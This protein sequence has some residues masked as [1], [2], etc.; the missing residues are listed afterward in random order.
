MVDGRGVQAAAFVDGKSQE[1][2]EWN[3]LAGL[4]VQEP[5]LFWHDCTSAS[6]YS[7]V[8]TPARTVMSLAKRTPPRQEI[9][10]S[11]S[12]DHSIPPA[13]SGPGPE[14]WI[15]D[16]SLSAPVLVI[17]RHPRPEKDAETTPYHPVPVPMLVPV[18][19]PHPYPSRV[20]TTGSRLAVGCSSVV[21]REPPG[22][23]KR[24]GGRDRQAGNLIGDIYSAGN[25]RL[26]ELCLAPALIRRLLFHRDRAVTRRP[27]EL[28]KIRIVRAASVLRACLS[29]QR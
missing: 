25:M 13:V 5:N 15:V 6:E 28:S 12:P 10:R 1:V 23:L 3:V 17:V 27:I 8:A 2:G 29:G 21:R 22:S 26:D 20:C 7:V 11:P 4:R 19:V 9:Q 16:G 24:G 14:V 18:P